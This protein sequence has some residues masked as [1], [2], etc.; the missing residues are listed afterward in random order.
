MNQPASPF[1]I[2]S[3]SKSDHLVGQFIRQSEPARPSVTDPVSQSDHSIDGSMITK[4][5][6]ESVIQYVSKPESQEVS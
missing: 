5:V 3:V 4:T 1:V 2:D 6:T